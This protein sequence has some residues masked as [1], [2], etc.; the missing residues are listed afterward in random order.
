MENTGRGNT[1][2]ETVAGGLKHP[3]VLPLTVYWV[4]MVGEAVVMPVM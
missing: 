4:L 2:T 1:E 3:F